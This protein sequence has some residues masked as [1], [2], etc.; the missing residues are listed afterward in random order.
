[1]IS[2][3]FSNTSPVPD[4][5]NWGVEV[6]AAWND[7]DTPAAVFVVRDDPDGAPEFSCVA[8]I[9][10]L[11]ELDESAG[12]I[13]RFYRVS[14]IEAVFTRP[15]IAAEWREKVTYAVQKLVDDLAE[16]ERITYTTNITPSA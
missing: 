14:S 3:H 10:Q 13:T 4:S 12:D 11:T 16:S 1:M 9:D 6:T 5:L 8:S 7:G 15:S 2:L